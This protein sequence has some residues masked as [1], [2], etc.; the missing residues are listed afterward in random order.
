MGIRIWTD[1]GCSGN[2]G[3]GGWAF[4]M[5]NG[6]NKIIAENYGGENATTNNR[7]ELYAVV[8]ALNYI[9][10]NERTR[11]DITLFTDS[12]YVQKGMSEWIKKWKLNGWK[13]A[14]NKPVKNKDLW[15]ELD[16]LSAGINIDWQW[17]KGHAGNEFNERCDAMTQLAILNITGR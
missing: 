11:E 15:L 16:K 17:V 10:E 7:M 4:V 5:D 14:G 6:G 13:S 1:G 9:H 12:Q 2:P 3:P 8:S